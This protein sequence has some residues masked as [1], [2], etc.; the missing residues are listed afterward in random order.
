LGAGD[1][2]W[3]WPVDFL[4]VNAPVLDGLDGAGDLKQLWARPFQ[5][6][7]TVDQQCISSAGLRR[8]KPLAAFPHDKDFAGS[9]V[10]LV[11]P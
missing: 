3:E 9:S 6:R 2:V 11:A 1:L 10:A 8:W 4:N 7:R 5:D